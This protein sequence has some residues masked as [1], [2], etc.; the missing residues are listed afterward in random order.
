L[1]QERKE[2]RKRKFIKR[3]ITFKVLINLA[4]NTWTQFKNRRDEI[5][6]HKKMFYLCTVIK[7][8]MKKMLTNR[9]IDLNDRLRKDVIM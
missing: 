6:L 2:A 8:R 1:K 4:T 3:W 7:R 5:A 9:G